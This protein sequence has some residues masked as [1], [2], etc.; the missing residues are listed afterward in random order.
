MPEP[1]LRSA[2]SLDLSQRIAQTSTV[3]ASPA[4]AAETIVAQTPPL[5]RSLAVTLGVLVTA[6]LAYTTG[7]TTASVQIRIRQTNIS[8]TIVYNSG[9][10][11]GGRNA[12]ALLCADSAQAFDLSPAA[13]Q[14]YV[15]TLQ[16][17][18]ATAVSTV[19]AAT[20]V[21]LAI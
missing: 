19:S 10:M 6:E 12:A 8:G 21:A 2:A 20:L 15:L 16:L 14:V 9:A 17:A 1:I 4:L 7:T 13:G 5:D 3:V 18:G 11:T